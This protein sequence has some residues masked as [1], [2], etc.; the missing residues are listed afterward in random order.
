MEADA[1]PRRSFLQQQT[2]NASSRKLIALIKGAYWIALLII[3]AITMASFVLLQQMM[4][5]QQRD[6]TLLTLASTQK[7]L[8]QRVVFLANTLGGAAR[9]DQ[10]TLVA[11]LRKAV[12]EFEAN[13]DLLLERTGADERSKA[14]FDPSSVEGV[15]FSY[16]HHLDLF[17]TEL[18]ANGWR[19]ISALE[20]ELG[21][22][23]AD[24]RAGKETAVLD[25]IV[26]DATLE[27]FTALGER[28]DAL[29]DA[30]L[31]ST[32][33]LHRTLFYSTIGVIILVALFIFRPMS[34]V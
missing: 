22:P 3:A 26:A 18:A 5:A 8:S 6:D 25:E 27:G 32:L 30:R 17:S 14:P 13:Y 1:H 24:Y 7:A 29:A 34:D 10:P 16:P 19:F 31:D 33:S 28:I 20:T 15:L 2:V 4:A 21:V 11:S 12:G 9:E 23:G